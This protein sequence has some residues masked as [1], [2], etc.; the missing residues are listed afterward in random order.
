MKETAKELNKTISSMLQLIKN[1]ESK[2]EKKDGLP[3]SEEISTLI[4][5][6]EVLIT[7]YSNTN[8]ES[9]DDR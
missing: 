6:Y 5:T 4:K 2:Q 9:S 3:T 7:I 8:N 1:F